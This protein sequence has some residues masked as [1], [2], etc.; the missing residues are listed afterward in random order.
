MLEAVSMTSPA[1]DMSVDQL[2]GWAAEGIIFSVIDAE[3][4]DEVTRVLLD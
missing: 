2:R 4:G 3:T 1:D